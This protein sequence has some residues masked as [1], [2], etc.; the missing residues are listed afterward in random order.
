[1][2]Q[3]LETALATDLLKATELK[4]E[5]A[6][7]KRKKRWFILLL[8]PAVVLLIALGV[9][10]GSADLSVGDV[11]I[12]ILHR[13]FPGAIDSIGGTADKIIWELRLPRVLMAVL[14]GAGLAGTGCVMQ[15]SLKN[16]LADPLF[17]GISSGAGFG[18]TLVIIFGIG[19]FTGTGATI[20]SAFIF[21]MAVSLVIIGMSSFKG[22]KPVTMLL[23]GL[24][25]TYL[26]MSL[27][28]L[29][30]YQAEA[31]AAKA[32]MMWMVGDLTDSDW[33]EVAILT[34]IVVVCLG[35]LFWKS[36]DLNIMGAGD[37]SAKSLGINVGRLR[38]FMMLVASLLTAAVVSFV[39]VIAFVGLVCPHICRMIIGNDNRFLLP[40]AVLFGAVLLL[41]ADCLARVVLSPVIL[42]PG[43]VTGLLG[44][45]F[46]IQL[47][48]RQR[49]ELF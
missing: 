48:M 40:A 5:Q 6:K 29:L 37:E 10:T 7:V 15:A 30:Q 1:M 13:F 20:V 32:S 11:F 21:A 18:A 14:A 41:G 42:P 9:Q 43:V 36:W 24:A 33:S 39:G 27:T 49:R 26:F 31:E 34:P 3:Q 23:V 16:P 28:Q 25:M 22:A 12:T 8:V 17:L 2:T 45:P 4:K 44:A 46:F 19:I 47:V 38:V 35:L